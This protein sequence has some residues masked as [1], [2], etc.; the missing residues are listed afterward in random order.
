MIHAA[1]IP[2]A[3]FSSERVCPARKSVTSGRP[4]C[5][6]SLGDGDGVQKCTP[7]GIRDGEGRVGGWR[8]ERIVAYAQ[9]SQ[10]SGYS[11]AEQEQTYL[12]GRAYQRA[13]L[14]L[15]TIDA[16]LTVAFRVYFTRPRL[17][18]TTFVKTPS[19]YFAF[20]V[21]SEPL[22]SH[23]RIRANLSRI[24]SLVQPR[25]PRERSATGNKS[26]GKNRRAIR[27]GNRDPR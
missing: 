4:V 26:V 1:R 23:S 21:R 9:P 10:E 17:E 7:F 25:E 11:N 3:R 8:R 18:T 2:R 27:Y 15:F 14:Q 12:P 20:P 24:I 6:K 13:R 22:S 16:H 5:N 19:R